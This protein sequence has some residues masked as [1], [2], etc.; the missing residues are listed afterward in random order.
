MPIT[1]FVFYQSP[2][3]PAEQDKKFGSIATA[4]LLQDSPKRANVHAGQCITM[5]TKEYLSTYDT[6]KRQVILF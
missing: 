6:Q 3:D 5:F 4:K 2:P 1:S